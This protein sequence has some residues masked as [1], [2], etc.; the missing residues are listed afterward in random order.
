[1]AKLRRIKNDT[2]RLM[3][4]LSRCPGRPRDAL[5]VQSLRDERA[6]RLVRYAARHVPYYRNLFAN[7]GLDPASFH[8]VDDLQRIPVSTKAD[9][10]KKPIVDLVS[11]EY[12]PASLIEHS[13]SGS[14]GIPFK[15]LRSWFDERCLNSIW[16]KHIPSQ[17]VSPGDRIAT[18][19][20]H[21]GGRSPD[22]IL[23]QRILNWLG[24]FRNTKINSL[25]PVQ[26]ILQAL[27]NCR[28]KRLMGY[29]SA[30]L[31]VAEAHRDT[32]ASAV[33]PK[34]THTFGEVLT[35]DIR[36]ELS[37]SF[38]A[39]VFDI[40]GSYEFGMVAYECGQSG[41]Y[42]VADE[43]IHLEILRNGER[44]GEG[45]SGILTATNLVV[46]AMP[47]IRFDI[48]DWVA[49]GPASCACGWQGSSICNIHGRMLDMFP[50]ADG[51]EI[52]PYEI[53][54]K[55]LASI[56]TITS[57]YQLIQE[58]VNRIVLSVV[59]VSSEIDLSQFDPFRR[60][61]A[62]FLGDQVRFEIRLVDH[63]DFEKS[64]KFRVSRSKVRSNYDQV[65][66]ES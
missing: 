31:R 57:Q 30:L 15:I 63:I 18:L 23:I 65:K 52:H 46:T 17:G 40:Y 24:L 11:D 45:E 41:V 43:A 38:G 35:P 22:R 44:V 51:R 8:S 2:G 62:A 20:G 55:L 27:E 16:M 32:R 61:I 50:L 1:M 47:F 37:R 7:H 5:S 58:S 49:R 54:V 19:T 34:S 6:A 26:E 53:V 64:G 12:D 28:P 33:A 66:S 10:K 48:G 59:P 56:F 42:H 25:L 13:T 21:R 14:S 60:E 39:P 4:C 3:A 36:Q 29:P 9:L